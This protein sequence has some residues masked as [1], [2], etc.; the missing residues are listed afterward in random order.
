MSVLQENKTDVYSIQCGKDTTGNYIIILFENKTRVCQY[1]FHTV[2]EAVS[3][4]L[5]LAKRYS[6]NL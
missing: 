5:Q 4:R 1:L 3:A 2:Q 6:I